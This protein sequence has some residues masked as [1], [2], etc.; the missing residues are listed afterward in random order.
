MAQ[1]ARQRWF[2]HILQAGLEEKL[3]SPAH[4]LS[5]VTPE[6]MAHNLPPELMSKILSSSLASG[7]MTAERLCEVLSPEVLAEHVPL[8]ILWSCISAGAERAGIV[9]NARP[10]KAS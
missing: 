9:D 10:D 7:S 6:V 3:W 5:F 4:V 1:G 8:E 2:S